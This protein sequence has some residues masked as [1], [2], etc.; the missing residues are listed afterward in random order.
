LRPYPF[1]GSEDHRA[2]VPSHVGHLA[3]ESPLKS[4]IAD[5]P[6]VVNNQN[7]W[8]EMPRDDEGRA[9]PHPAAEML[10][11]GVKEFLDFR[12]GYDFVGL[13]QNFGLG[14]AQDSAASLEFREALS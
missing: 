4:V 12:N 14:H 3:Q 2:T 11:G 6:Q 10:Q 5:R 7:L 8:F 1:Y 9:R 13:S